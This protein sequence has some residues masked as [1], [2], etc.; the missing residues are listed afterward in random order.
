MIFLKIFLQFC[1]GISAFLVAFLDYKW[2]DKRTEKFKKTRN[3]LIVITF[4]MFLVNIRITINDNNESN[5]LRKNLENV[6][7]SLMVIK[8][9]GLNLDH[10]LDPFLEYVR[11]KYPGVPIEN[12]L[13]SLKQ[14]VTTL[15]QKT[16]QLIESDSL[17]KVADFE[18]E[19][20]KSTPPK[21][22]AKIGVTN[23]DELTIVVHLLNNIPIKL[24]YSISTKEGMELKVFII[25]E[26]PVIIPGE[27]ASDYFI[28]YGKISDLKYINE[29]PINL[30]LKIDYESIYFKETG[31]IDLKRTLV[32][33]FYFDVKNKIIRKINK[34][35]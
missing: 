13:E 5:Q 18:F 27:G 17:R 11:N 29:K 15:E 16:N 26:P 3:M 14:E 7:D 4:I 33:D 21:I 10:K 1:I 8:N 6:Q 23:E 35:V 25:T 34:S 19:K 31:N 12:A 28:T 9:I 24:W 20:L 32:K 22:D 2:H 30:R